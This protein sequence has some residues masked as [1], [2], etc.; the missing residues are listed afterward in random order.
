MFFSERFMEMYFQTITISLTLSFSDVISTSDLSIIFATSIG[1]L[2][3]SSSKLKHFEIRRP[4]TSSCCLTLVA[5]FNSENMICE[6]TGQSS[7]I[8]IV[9][10]VSHMTM[11]SSASTSFVHFGHFKRSVSDII[12][13]NFYCL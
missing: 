9:W 4:S 3:P 5:E 13:F 11:S 10:H 2:F 12:Y 1:L 7:T 6:L 8:G